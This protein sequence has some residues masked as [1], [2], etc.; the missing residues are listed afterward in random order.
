MG[1]L[2]IKICGIKDVN[3]AVKAAHAG[4]NYI[5]IIFHQGSPRSVTMVEA[6]LIAQAARNAGALPVAVFTNQ[7]AADMQYICAECEINIVQLH[8]ETV[9]AQHHLLPL[10]YQRIYVMH[11]SLA[12]ELSAEAGFKYLDSE[13]DFILIDH[14]ES[15][16]GK[17]IENIKYQLDFRW[18]LAGGLNAVNVT[19][20]IAEF[21]PDGVDAASGVESSRGNKDIILIQQFVSTVRGCSYAT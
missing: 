15:G 11:P 20:A 14:R 6:Q 10:A 9:R 19:N 2:L 21:Q 1:N 17:R 4:V 8:G 7:S 12:G 3:T 16:Q 18:F 13:R 5:G